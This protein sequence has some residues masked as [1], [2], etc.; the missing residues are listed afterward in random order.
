MMCKDSEKIS[1]GLSLLS[2]LVFHADMDS[3]YTLCSYMHTIAYILEMFFN[4]N[5]CPPTCA[6]PDVSASQNV[7]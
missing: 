4:K 7:A 1:N 3:T 5:K 2:G 6:F